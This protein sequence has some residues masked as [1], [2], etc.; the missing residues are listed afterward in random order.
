MVLT[1]NHF[2]LYLKVYIMSLNIFSEAP[3]STIITVL[4]IGLTSEK[5]LIPRFGYFQ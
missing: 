3:N 4:S 1:F 5:K 2:N